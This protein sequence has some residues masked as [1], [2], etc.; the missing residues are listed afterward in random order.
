MDSYPNRQ[1]L[2]HGRGGESEK[3][4]GR[5]GA[6]VSMHQV[7]P[8][9]I[10]FQIIP[11]VEVNGAW[12]IDDQHMIYL[13]DQCREKDLIKQV[14]FQ[15]EVKSPDDWLNIMKRPSN[16]VHTI[17]G[18][19]KLPYLI[20]WLNDWGRTFA[21]AHFIT[22]PRA[23]GKHTVEL[24]YQSFEYWFSFKRDDGTPL[25]QTIIGRTPAHRPIVTNFLYKLNAHVLGEI[26]RMAYDVYQQKDVGIVISYITREDLKN[27]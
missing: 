14:F 3:A 23:W 27:G 17:W 18:P 25:L 24:L 1:M 26:P 11:Y 16:V 10:K 9:A 21:F 5:G 13:Y 15:G 19:D 22:W 20:A 6:R 8:E 2:S 4:D 7:R 12:S